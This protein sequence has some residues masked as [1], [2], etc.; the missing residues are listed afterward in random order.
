MPKDF[1]KTDL[2]SIYDLKELTYP[3]TWEGR[4]FNVFFFIEDSPTDFWGNTIENAEAYII[5]RTKHVKDI[6]DGVLISIG[7]VSDTGTGLETD[8]FI[9][10]TNS[11]LDISGIRQYYVIGK[12]YYGDDGL[13]MQIFLS[14]NK[15]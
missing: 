8:M 6:S 11:E 2:D 10:I 15:P 3:A 7:N 1:F 14:E 12:K 9:D 13:Q 4:S 5:A